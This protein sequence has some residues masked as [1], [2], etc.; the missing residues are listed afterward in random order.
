MYNCA[1]GFF[2]V[3]QIRLEHRCDI[4]QDLAKNLCASG[5]NILDFR[6]SVKMSI[7]IF[8]L[9]ANVPLKMVKSV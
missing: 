9:V 7:V 6:F 5:M 4:L 2:K 8:C 1:L 3:T